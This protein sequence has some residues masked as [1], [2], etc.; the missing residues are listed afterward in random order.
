VYGLKQWISCHFRERHDRL[1][2][3]ASSEMY[4]A[5]YCNLIS[6]RMP[7]DSVACFNDALLEAAAFWKNLCCST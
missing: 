3:H 1:I 4:R 2:S 7:C 5:V 6:S